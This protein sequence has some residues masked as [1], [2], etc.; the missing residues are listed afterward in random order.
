M[1]DWRCTNPDDDGNPCGSTTVQGP[2][3]GAY[4]CTECGAEYEDDGE[5]VPVQ[6]GGDQ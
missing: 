5:W 1:G 2:G 4:Y 6:E 3:D